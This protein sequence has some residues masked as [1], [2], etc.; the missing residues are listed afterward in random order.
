M[1]YSLLPL[2]ITLLFLFGISTQTFSQVVFPVKQG[3]KWGLIDDK[4]K[5]FLPPTYDAVGKIDQFGYSVIQDA[6]NV[7]L[8]NKRGGIVFQPQFQDIK[9]VDSLLF[10]VKQNDKWTV[11]NKT[12][13]VI[14]KEKYSSKVKPLDWK[15]C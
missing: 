1:K 9:V 11:I 14:L 13:K 5:E 7:G 10:A 12:Q 2:F 3:Q 6:S 15:S 4:G 8:I